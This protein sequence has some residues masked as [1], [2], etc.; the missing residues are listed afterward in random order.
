M[1]AIRSYYEKRRVIGKL[2]KHLGSLVGKHVALLGVA[3]KPN[4]DDMRE[5]SYNFV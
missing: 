4:T 1:Y 5:A 2:E 3:F